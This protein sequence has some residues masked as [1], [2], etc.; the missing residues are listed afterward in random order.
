[1]DGLVEFFLS[2]QVSPITLTTTFFSSQDRVSLSS[3]PGCLGTHFVD[4]VWGFCL[5]LPSAGTNDMHHH[6]LA[7]FPLLKHFT[8]GNWKNLCLL[9]VAVRWLNYWWSVKTWQ[10]IKITCDFV[11]PLE[12]IQEVPVA[13]PVTQNATY[14]EGI[15]WDKCHYIGLLLVHL[16]YVNEV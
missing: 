11:K 8:R 16:Q 5:Y 15:K 1:M 10:S 14:A 6:H 3:S 4:W 2:M 9:E 12:F 13:Y 7:H